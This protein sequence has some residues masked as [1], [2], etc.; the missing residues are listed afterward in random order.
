MFGRV[1]ARS[2]AADL[3][4]TGTGWGRDI[5]SRVYQVPFVRSANR[6]TVT[7]YYDTAANLRRIGV[8]VDIGYPTPFP[9]EPEYCPPPRP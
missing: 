5:D 8:P 1:E 9:V 3:R 2:A 7:I 4:G 6:R